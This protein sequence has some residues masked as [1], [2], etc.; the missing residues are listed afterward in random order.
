MVA[1][2]T[3]GCASRIT[4]PAVFRAECA[5]VTITDSRLFSSFTL[6]LHRGTRDVKPALQDSEMRIT[7][8]F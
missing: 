4:G 8:G 7:F 3:F 1:T 5:Q 2:G 6:Q